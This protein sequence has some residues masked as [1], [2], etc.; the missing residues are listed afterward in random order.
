MSARDFFL[1][2]PPIAINDKVENTIKT[3]MPIAIYLYPGG[4]IKQLVA[5]SEAYVP[6]L[7][8]QT[9]FKKPL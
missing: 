2:I 5:I 4:L 6:T 1:K 7:T 8:I 9:N 3:R